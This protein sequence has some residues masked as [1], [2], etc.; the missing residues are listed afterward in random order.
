[1][2]GIN[3]LQIMTSF[4]PLYKYRFMSSRSFILFLSSLLLSHPAGFAQSKADKKVMGRLKADITYL[5]CDELEGRRTGT[6]GEHK[7][8]AYIEKRY[9]ESRINPYKGKYFY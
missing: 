2:V 8:A 6:E 9:K 1:M 5:A 7:A 3:D 4:L